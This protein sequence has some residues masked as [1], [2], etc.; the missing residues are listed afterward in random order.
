[1]STPLV[2]PDPLVDLRD[3]ART[4]PR[5]V[6]LLAGR[7]YWNFPDDL[8]TYPAVRIYDSV[9]PTILPSGGGIPAVDAHIAWD[10]FGGAKTDFLAVKA[11][12]ITLV[13]ILNELQPDTIIGDTRVKNV[14][15]IGGI[16]SPD[17][18]TGFPRYVLDTR[19][20]CTVTH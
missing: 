4:H 11:I 17:P 3:W 14:D 18:A 2:L 20:L 19:W 13:A 6:P 1:M 7:V 5:L 16:N 10:I 8:N 15:A 12:S 9:V